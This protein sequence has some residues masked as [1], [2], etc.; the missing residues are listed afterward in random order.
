MKKLTLLFAV[1]VMSFATTANASILLVGETVLDAA[2]PNANDFKAELNALGFEQL[3]Q[4]DI[5]STSRQKLT[6]SYHGAESGFSNSFEIDGTNVFTEA[7]ESWDPVGTVIGSINVEIGDVLG[8]TGLDLL[9]FIAGGGNSGVDARLGEAGFGIFK[10]TDGSGSFLA[11]DGRMYFG[12]DDSGA[13]P[14]DNHDDMIISMA[15]SAVPEP[16]SLIVWTGLIGLGM[17]SSRRRKS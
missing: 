12:F 17:V 13:G 2:I 16:T 5:V 15:F 3:V 4:G 10:D 9:G 7:D 8:V 11:S 6:F 1:A 14:D